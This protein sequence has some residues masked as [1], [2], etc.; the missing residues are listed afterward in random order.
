MNRMFPFT[1][2]GIVGG[3]TAAYAFSKPSKSW[4]KPV[5]ITGLAIL[6]FATGYLVYSYMQESDAKVQKTLSL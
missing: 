6:A 2:M 3:G 1:I 5:A 4:S